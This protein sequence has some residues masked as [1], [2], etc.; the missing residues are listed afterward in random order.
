M[1]FHRCP[2]SRLY[3]L[4]SQSQTATSTPDR[5]QLASSLLRRT[6]S[7]YNSILEL[8]GCLGLDLWI[9]QLRSVRLSEELRRHAHECHTWRVP[10]AETKRAHGAGWLNDGSRVQNKQ[11]ASTRP[12]DSENRTDRNPIEDRRT[13]GLKSPRKSRPRSQGVEL[14][15]SQTIAAAAPS[16]AANQQ[17]PTAQPRAKGERFFPNP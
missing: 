7:H 15:G 16:R 13:S 4:A 14:C 5:L 10:C 12:C 8:P 9:G 3:S 6:M 11:T 17:R 2:D 1:K